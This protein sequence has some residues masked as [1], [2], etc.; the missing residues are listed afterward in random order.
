MSHIKSFVRNVTF[1]LPNVT[2]STLNR[3]GRKKAFLSLFWVL[4]PYGAYVY[5][6]NAIDKFSEC[7]ESYNI[8]AMAR[9]CYHDNYVSTYWHIR[10]RT[11]ELGR[12][13]SLR[14]AFRRFSYASLQYAPSPCILVLDKQSRY[15][16][17]SVRNAHVTYMCATLLYISRPKQQH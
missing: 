7:M 9:R 3:A 11:Y 5:E 12:W 4:H 10:S 15:S 17:Y 8:T 13:V 6:T 16:M 2:C 14:T 1:G